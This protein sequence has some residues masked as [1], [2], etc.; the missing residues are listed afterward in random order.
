MKQKNE[1]SSSIKGYFLARH[2]LACRTIRIVDEDIFCV[3]S[4]E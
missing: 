2:M 4:D 3:H 1:S